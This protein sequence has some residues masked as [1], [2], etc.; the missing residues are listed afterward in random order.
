MLFMVNMLAAIFAIS[1]FGPPHPGV[2]R[3]R[4]FQTGT[5][6][7]K[8]SFYI[9]SAIHKATGL[10][11]PGHSMIWLVLFHHSTVPLKNVP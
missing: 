5:A 8:Q 1:D 2:L 11:V 6:S 4:V 3:D 10:M 9:Y 7:A